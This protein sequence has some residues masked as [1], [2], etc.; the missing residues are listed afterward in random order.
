MFMHEVY[1]MQIGQISSTTHHE[2]DF[3]VFL[4]EG[5]EI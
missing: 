1:I 2:I 4:E 5:N 3:T